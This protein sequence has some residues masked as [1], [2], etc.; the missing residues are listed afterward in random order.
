[1]V[2]ASSGGSRSA[3]RKG[4][5]RGSNEGEPDPANHLGN[6]LSGR[7]VCRFCAVAAGLTWAALL[8]LTGQQFLSQDV[9]RQHHSESGTEVNERVRV[10]ETENAQLRQANA[11][12][13]MELERK[14]RLLA[15]VEQKVSEMHPSWT[16]SS[17]EEEAGASGVRGAPPVQN[18]WNPLNLRGSGTPATAQQLLAPGKCEFLDNVDYHIAGQAAEDVAKTRTTADECCQICMNK[19]IERKGS[20]IVA[21]LSTPQDSPASACWIKAGKDGSA[22]ASLAAVS[23]PGVKAC[24]PPGHQEMPTVPPPSQGER[25]HDARLDAMQAALGP[26]SSDRQTLR[27][28]A[29]RDAIKHAWSGYKR[30]GWGMDEIMPVSGRGRNKGFNHAVSMVDALDTLWLAGMKD[31]FNEAK[32][33]IVQNLP[34]K[35]TGLGGQVSVFETTIRTLG[36]LL[37]A[38]DLSREKSLLDVAVKLGRRILQTINDKGVTPYTF[39]GGKG[40]MGCPSL[41]ESGTIQ[42]E[43]RYLSHVTG[44]PA[45]EQKTMKFYDTLLA[46]HDSFDGLYPNCY[47]AGKGKITFGA[48]GDSFYEYLVKVFIQGG[49]SEGFLWGMYEKAVNGMKKHLTT[50]GDDG[51]TYLGIFNYDGRGGGTL[52]QEMEH[53]T[54]FVPGWLALGAHTPQG[55]QSRKDW[56]EL[57]ESIATTC[58]QM[59]EK[60]PTGIG[61]ERVKAMMMDLS[62]TNTKEYILRPEAAEGWWYMFE[63][64]KE[65]KYRE[66]GWK[67]FLAFEQWLWVPNGYASLKDVSRRS[68]TYIDRMESFFLAET[69]KYLLL[70]QDPDHAMKL[71]RYVFNTEAHPLSILQFAPKP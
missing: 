37:S 40:G 14:N 39:A 10:L 48:D 4:R 54:C 65:D 27:T 32:N 71:D 8:V 57:A 35:V 46:G 11:Q 2:K 59:Y 60:Q 18:S 31:E 38:Y 6:F 66:W 56:M 22:L 29:V 24:L 42:L 68:K 19:N 7:H 61:P 63:F 5:Q 33:W 25:E 49:R 70:L 41:A 52:A 1:M 53:L 62:R 43:M 21:I 51:L 67:T 69:M 3:P 64:T 17:F 50:V 47:Q 16:A 9:T 34:S 45:F 26:A 55:E 15:A 23:K 30:L 13:D 12:K 36:G 44:D 28:N 58:W 20:C